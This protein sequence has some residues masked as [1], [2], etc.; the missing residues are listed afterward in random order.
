MIQGS[1]LI[2]MI[3][4]GGSE[5]QVLVRDQHRMRRRGVQHYCTTALCTVSGGTGKKDCIWDRYLLCS[6]KYNR[7]EPQGLPTKKKQLFV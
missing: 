6:G 3:D 1:L 7:G 2:S 5:R 4:A